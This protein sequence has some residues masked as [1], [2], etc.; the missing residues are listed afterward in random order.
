[1]SKRLLFSLCLVLF[2][3]G[4]HAQTVEE[5]KAQKAEKEAQIAALQGEVGAL[6]GQIDAFPG[7]KFGSGGLIGLNFAQYNKWL[8]NP[9]PNNYSSTLAFA[10]NGFAN[11]DREKYFWRNNGGLNLA[12][13]KLV[14]DSK[15]S[16][17][18]SIDYEPTADIL[19]IAS[20]FGYKLNDKWAASALGE[21][22]TSVIENFNNPGYLDIG[23]GLTWTPMSNLVVV[24]HPLNYNIVFADDD[25]AY[26]SSLGCKIVADYTQALPRGVS[27]RSNLSA[28]VSYADPENLSNWTWVNG[29]N[30]KAWKGIGVG[31]EF[32]LRGNA[33]EAYNAFLP[34]RLTTLQATNPDLT[35]EQLKT[36]EPI[37]KATF[38]NDLQTYW[39][40]GLTYTL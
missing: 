25:F 2:A 3:F 38:D 34:G 30:F 35:L 33:Q 10:A 40:L 32:G 39:L 19:N 31:F 8:T 20:L 4:L 28:F 14:L 21:Y 11:L 5:L 18:D 6:Q 26:E 29:F 7:W 1:M 36:D 23:A 16:D 37:D 12:W 22:R 9:N 13:T 27:W 17:A 15:A 24:F